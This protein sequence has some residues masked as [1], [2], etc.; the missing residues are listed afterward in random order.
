MSRARLT[1][2]L[3]LIA[4]LFAA[5]YA[6]QPPSPEAVINALTFRNI[7]PFRTAAWV[8]EIA[9]PESP[10]RDHLYTIYAATRSGG[11]WKTTNAG[12]TWSADLRQRRR[13][14]G[15][16]GRARAIESRTS[17]GWAPATR[18]TR[19][20]RT[21]ARAS[22]SPP[23]PARP[24]SS[25]ACPTRTTSRGIVIHPTNPD[26]V[27]V[28]AMGHLFSRNEERGVFRTTGRRQDVEEGPLRQ[29][30]R[31]RDRPRDQ[32]EERRAT[33]YAA[34]YD[35]ERRPW[36]IV[37]SGP[38]SAHLR[39]RRRRRQVDEA[40]RRPADRQD[41]PHRPRHLSEEPARSSTRC[42]RTRT[43]SAGARSARR[44]RDQPARR[45]HHRQRA[46]SHRRRRED[47]A[48]NVDRRQRRRRQGA[49]FV[50]PDPDQSARRPDGHRHQRLDVHLA[51]RRQD[52]GHRTSSA[53]CSATSASMW[54]DPRGQAT[55]S[56]S[57]ATAA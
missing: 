25:W 51:R 1:A 5:G 31:R 12:T 42:S 47:V 28:A 46:V 18:R 37:E 16:R 3:T 36:Q 49:V 17:S 9:V 24:G 10:L 20:R 55:A 15:R 50:Q 32:P 52:L 40:E 45:R 53:A 43:R 34:M 38:E 22:S 23:T 4:C 19:G 7:G 21:R 48:A 56:S 57:A 33:L 39:D 6:R 35:K 27:Y 30:R 14:G 44:E 54:W 41:R 26:V 2:T 13:R 8:T 11:L 29:R